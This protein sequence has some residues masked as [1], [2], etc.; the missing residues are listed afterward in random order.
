MKGYHLVLD[1]RWG[2][3]TDADGKFELP[4]LPPGKYD[5][6]VWHEKAGYLERS[7]K[8]EINGDKELSLKFPPA[9]FAQFEGPRPKTVYVASR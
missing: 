6:K 1:H 5:L 2:A 4:E 7:V 3:I 9:K 8:L